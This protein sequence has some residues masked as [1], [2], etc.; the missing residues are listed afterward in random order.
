MREISINELKELQVEMLDAIHAYCISNKINYTLAAGTLLGAIRHKGYIPWDEDID[1]AM[2]RPDYM[3]FI[4]GFNSLNSDYYV[5]SPE[6]NWDYYAPYANVCDRRT[7]LYEGANGHR[8]ME[9][10]IKI[11]VFPIDGLPSDETEFNLE[12]RKIHQIND[13]LSSK[14]HVLHKIPLRYYKTILCLLKIRMKTFAKSYS[15][16][17]KELNSIARRTDYGSTPFVNA[18]VFS[19]INC[20]LDINIFRKYI[21]VDF[22]GKK[23]MACEGYDVWLK[24]L[25]GDYMQLPPEEERIP[26]HGFTAYWKNGF[27]PEDR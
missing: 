17:Q 6:L 10:G 12:L 26:H 22:E 9:I 19:I 24:A 11:D 14:R 25:Y 18:W 27:G 23:Y 5:I 3:K 8:G 13:I 2:P 4:K 15:A 20:R 7:I 16:Y 1:I 21:D